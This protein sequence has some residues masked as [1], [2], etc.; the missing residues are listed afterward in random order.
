[1]VKSATNKG[2]SFKLTSSSSHPFN[3]VD[4]DVVDARTNVVN[5]ADGYAK[6]ELT[7]GTFTWRIEPAKLAPELRKSIDPGTELSG[8]VDLGKFAC[9]RFATSANTGISANNPFDPT[10]ADDSTSDPPVYCK[11]GGRGPFLIEVREHGR[12]YV[13]PIYTGL[14]Y[15]RMAEDLPAATFGANA[16]APHNGSS[17]PEAAV[18]A[19][20]N[21]IGSV[22]ID[23]V[24][25]LLPP[26][27]FRALYDY[28][29]A[30]HQSLSDSELPSF[31]FSVNPGAT[32]E[33]TDTKG[34]KKVLIQSASGQYNAGSTCDATT[35]ECP[36]DSSSTSRGTW[37][38]N[39]T[40][41]TT[42]E[43]S[44]TPQKDCASDAHESYQQ[45]TFDF[46]LDAFFV[47]TVQRGGKWYVSPSLTIAD[48]AHV[49]LDALKPCDVAIPNTTRTDC[50]GTI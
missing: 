15:W 26:D 9:S 8:S 21:A 46:H 41:M 48:Y 37:Q 43:P 17:T 42:T 31:L 50:A 10:G 32:L 7:G 40:C 38:L 1:M 4:L 35:D 22:D 23:G 14:E 27:E 18:T 47:D 33:V 12:W 5:L 3:G 25:A 28:R 30:I 16:S 24:L 11:N 19:M 45:G 2:K 29:A 34:G 6:V 13:S 39:G 20:A 49:L 44:G 36:S